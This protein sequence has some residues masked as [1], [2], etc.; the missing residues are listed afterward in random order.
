MLFYRL[1]PFSIQGDA[2]I[3]DLNPGNKF[4]EILKSTQ[5][6]LP[7]LISLDFFPERTGIFKEY[8]QFTYTHGKQDTPICLCMT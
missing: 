8:A 3:M 6:R 2:L 7:L 1:L 5:K 4:L